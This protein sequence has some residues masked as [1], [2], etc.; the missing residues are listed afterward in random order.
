MPL[1]ARTG[2]A[3]VGG[4]IPANVQGGRHA[5]R[6]A[7]IVRYLALRP[8]P[9]FPGRQRQHHEAAMR[10]AQFDV[11]IA[12]TH[13]SAEIDAE[14]RE[15]DAALAEH[16]FPVGIVGID[17]LAGLVDRALRAQHPLHQRRFRSG[18]H[19]A[20]L[21]LMLHG[22]AEGVLGPTMMADFRRQAGVLDRVRLGTDVESARFDEARLRASFQQLALGLRALHVAESLPPFEQ[23]VRNLYFDTAVYDADSLAM[24]IRKAEVVLVENLEAGSPIQQ[25]ITRRTGG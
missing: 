7:H 19:V 25:E 6:L 17:H 9:L 8:Y 2:A 23:A 16:R 20:D 24:L 12:R 21:P 4:V 22:S 18:E 14:R 15:A 1:P 5:Q 13:A 11:R 10:V 3:K